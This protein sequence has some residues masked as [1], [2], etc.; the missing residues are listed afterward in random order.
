MDPE[1]LL[2]DKAIV[3]KVAQG[4]VRRRKL[5]LGQKQQQETDRTT[6]M[7]RRPA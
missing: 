4:K 6:R 7:R 3:A 2:V 1:P 5:L